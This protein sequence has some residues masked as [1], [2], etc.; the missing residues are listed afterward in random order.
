MNAGMKTA[1]FAF[2]AMLLGTACLAFGPWLVRLADV[3]PLAVGFWRLAIAAPV[4]IAISRVAEGKAPP[5]D[6]RLAIVLA[7]AGAAFALDLS[8]WHE[9]IVRTSLA[10]AT[11]MGNATS[12]I[13]AGWGF[14]VARRLPERTA[15]IAL[16][17]AFV[18]V[19][20]L[21]GRSYQLSPRGL[22]GDLLSLA[23]AFFYTIYLIAIGRARGRLQPLNTLAMV[24]VAAMAVML[25]IAL[26][27]EGNIW[28]QDW[29][30][31]AGLALTSQLLGQGLLVYAVAYLE[32]VVVGLCLLIQPLIAGTIGWIVYGER[33]GPLE[34]MGASMIA[35]A[36]VLVR[37]PAG[38]TISNPPV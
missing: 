30:P 11:L 2:P 33:L 18:G 31:L 12:F 34:L 4:L 7:I 6:R 19:L 8:T 1:R 23:A 24:T 10:N 20:L 38:K 32:P 13:F 14:L 21:V 26:S 22:T 36:L 9:G 25:V 37:R 28:P 27:L 35:V 29:L 15:T 17:L 5:L 16:T 3:G